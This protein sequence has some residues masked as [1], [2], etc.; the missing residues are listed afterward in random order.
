MREFEENI[1]LWKE[2]ESI[3]AMIVANSGGNTGDGSPADTSKNKKRKRCNSDDGDENDG[4]EVEDASEDNANVNANANTDPSTPNKNEDL[5]FSADKE[6][7]SRRFTA[8]CKT[9]TIACKPAKQVHST[10]SSN[11]TTANNNINNNNINNSSNTNNHNSNSNSNINSN[12]NSNSNINSNINSNNNINSNSNSNS[13]I[14]CNSNPEITSK[15]RILLELLQD[16][17]FHPLPI[18]QPNRDISSLDVTLQHDYSK[19]TVPYFAVQGPVATS[20]GDECPGCVRGWNHFCPILQRHFPAVEYRSKLQPPCSSLRAN[21]I[22]LGYTLTKQEEE[23]IGVGCEGSG[24]ASGSDVYPPD[25]KRNKNIPSL[26]LTQPSSRGDD[27]VQ[28]VETAVAIKMP[29]PSSWSDECEL[30]PSPNTGSIGGNTKDSKKATRLL[31]TK[32]KHQTH[33]KDRDYDAIL[34]KSKNNINIDDNKKT[35]ISTMYECGKCRAIIQSNVGCITCRRGQLVVD[36]SKHEP[37]THI[38][39]SP[40]LLSN[41]APGTGGGDDAD[42]SIHSGLLKVQTVMLGRSS[43]KSNAFEKQTDG[44]RAIAHALTCRPWKPNAVLQLTKKCIPPKLPSHVSS[45]EEEEGEDSND[46]SDSEDDSDDDSSSEASSSTNTSSQERVVVATDNT[47]N[48]GG[49]GRSTTT[50]KKKKGLEGDMDALSSPNTIPSIAPPKKSKPSSSSSATSTTTNTTGKQTSST[51]TESSIPTRKLTRRQTRNSSNLKTNNHNNNT[52]NDNNHHHKNTNEDP[53]TCRQAKTEKHKSE[54]DYIQRRCLSIAT[55]GILLGL[56]RRDPL[57]LFAEPVSTSVEDY[58]KIIKRPIDMTRI[59]EKVLAESYTSL[60]AFVNDA[61]LLC[62]NSQM[63]NPPGSIYHSTSKELQRALGLLQKRAAD[64]MGAIKNAHSAYFSRW[65]NYNPDYVHKHH[66]NSNN[67]SDNNNNTFDLEDPFHDLRHRWPGAA[68][69]LEDGDWLRSE[70]NSDFIRTAENENSYYGAFAVRRVAKAAEASLAKSPFTD[71]TYEP[72]TRRNYIQDEDLWGRIDCEVRSINQPSKLLDH[73]TWREEDVL[74]LLKKVQKR[75]V[76]ARI[77]SESGCA[78]CDGSRKD[79]AIKLAQL[80]EGMMKTNRKANSED[81]VRQRISDSRLQQSTGLASRKERERL[82]SNNRKIGGWSKKKMTSTSF[83]VKSA[84]ARDTSVSIRGSG[85][86]GW[87]LFADHPFKKGELVAEY[88]GE[89]IGNPIADHR[90]KFYE[91]RRI[92]DYQFRVSA[93]L[94]IDATMHGGHAR[95]INQ[96]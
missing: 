70:V 46:D 83:E 53:I 29:P 64:W 48:D 28:F 71:E 63:F 8:L 9:S 86:H 4:D 1:I 12:S 19:T 49:G 2:D 11:I 17:R 74:G 95:Y 55:C 66:T 36:M 43:I 45:S 54:V 31:L 22:G 59:K 7:W 88:V 47:K 6:H 65:S 87:G 42:Y 39:S 50:A 81:E 84:T 57:R 67:N 96:R 56:M 32:G 16:I 80:E 51:T 72:C 78:R 61:R 91:E 35:T 34:H 75:R 20:V 15:N 52:N 68:E 73:P 24:D 44:D 60:G 38:N 58:H 21:R 85:I 14:N 37:V 93:G 18:I 10:I 3:K 79:E 94:V 62:A 41:T 13:N 90:E 76:E 89:Y 92:Q 77:T 33:H 5:I 30:P 82:E 25:K 27:I 26:G 40:R 69:L 23:G